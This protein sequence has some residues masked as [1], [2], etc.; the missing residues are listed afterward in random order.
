MFKKKKKIEFNNDE[1]RLVL[2]SLTD[3]RNA[4][5]KENKYA[6]SVNEIIAKLN[7]KMKVDKYDIGIIINGLDKKRKA[8]IT[9]EQDTTAIDKLLLNLLEVHKSL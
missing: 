9:E 3:F 6:D 5:L 4:L 8:I 1:L 2:Y 7:N